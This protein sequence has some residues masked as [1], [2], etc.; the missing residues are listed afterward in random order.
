MTPV[1]PC[2]IVKKGEAFWSIVSPPA[3]DSGPA[4]RASAMGRSCATHIAGSPILTDRGPWLVTRGS[5]IYGRGRSRF[6]EATRDRSGASP[7]EP[8]GVHRLEPS[9]CTIR[10]A[11]PQG[12]L[13]LRTIVIVDPVTPRWVTIPGGGSMG[14]SALAVLLVF[15]CRPS[16]DGPAPDAA[17]GEC[18]PT[19]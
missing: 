6:R 9:L 5:C 17:L 13:S 15:G 11:R 14:I 3:F 19:R 8:E 2:S 1:E 7:N 10:S 16:A 18:A 4:L 12:G